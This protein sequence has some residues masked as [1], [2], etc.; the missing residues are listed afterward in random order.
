MRELRALAPE[1]L[2]RAEQRLL[3]SAPGARTAAAKDFGIDQTL[4]LEQLRLTPAE[5]ARQMLEI[6]QEVRE[7]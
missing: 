3:N 5:R 6:F 1:E 4:L 2:S 7:D